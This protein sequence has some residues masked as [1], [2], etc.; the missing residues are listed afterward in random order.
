M[1]VLRIIPTIDPEVGGPSNSAVNQAIAE[2]GAGVETTFVFTGDARS[3]SSTAPARNR[4]EA[5]GVRTLMFPRPSGCSSQA[6]LWGISA[7][8][9]VWLARNVSRFDV[10]HLHYVWTMSTIIGAVLGSRARR[11][12]VLTAH[13]SLTRYDIDTASGSPFKRRL[14][15]GLRRFLMRR[16]DVVVCASPLEARDSL[17]ADDHG[18]VIYHPVVEQ[19]RSAP[20]AEPSKPPFVVGYLGR[21]H[22]KKNVDVAL[23][24]IADLPGSRLVVC[25]DGDEQYRR[26]LRDLSVELGVDDRTDWR[27]HVD[28]GGRQAMFNECHVTVMPSTYECFGMAG[29]EAMAAGIPVVVTASTGIAA[30]VDQQKAGA[31][32]APGDA[33]ALHEALRSLADATVSERHAIRKRAIAAAAGSLSF[34]AYGSAIRDV[35][36]DLCP[37]HTFPDHPAPENTL[38]RLTAA[39]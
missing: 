30:I 22:P 27:G 8:L 4:L 5:A 32:V 12:V 6:G 1:R 17:T 34:A 2:A 7:P 31:V 26:R 14:K 36:A 10:V 35:Y 37:D 25:G 3:A 29:A 38:E 15:L 21:L 13:E 20:A 23:R 24:A 19:P 33:D 18:V 16:V 11:P 28:A 39:S 9:T